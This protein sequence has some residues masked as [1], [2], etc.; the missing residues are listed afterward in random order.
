MSKIPPFP[1]T[2]GTDLDELKPMWAR[3]QRNSWHGAEFP[4]HG[5]LRRD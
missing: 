3:N 5:S 1:T 2:K 4:F